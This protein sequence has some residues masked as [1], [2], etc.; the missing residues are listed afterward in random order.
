VKFE[1]ENPSNNDNFE[2]IKNIKMKSYLL[3]LF[4]IAS[5]AI[6]FS[7]TIKPVPVKLSESKVSWKGYKVTG[8]HRGEIA[9]SF[10]ELNIEDGVL[11]GGKFVIDM[12]SINCTDLSGESKGKL[13]GH[14]KSED[15]FS[16]V[17][18]PEASMVITSVNGTGSYYDVVAD[19]T[20]K[21][22]TNS[23]KFNITLTKEKAYARLKIDRSEFD[24][25]YGSNSFFENLAD[26]AIYD[27]FDL[28][29]VLSY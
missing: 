2:P 28:D 23:V 11:K 27:D 16:V 7:N 8:S 9:M 1:H 25:K 12:S 10:G 15:F 17:K 14:L 5:F 13:E 26:R 18:F 19:L 3:S 24:V 22:N 4:A 21:G 29:V 6:G 20:I